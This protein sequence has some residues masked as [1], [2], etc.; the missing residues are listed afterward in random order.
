MLVL[1]AGRTFKSMSNDWPNRLTMPVERVKEFAE[2]SACYQEALKDR[3]ALDCTYKLWS[4]MTAAEKAKASKRL[5]STA[6]NWYVN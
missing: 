3:G 5:P 2:L 4:Q 6:N 1:L